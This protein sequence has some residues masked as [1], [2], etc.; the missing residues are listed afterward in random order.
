[1]A[2]G[3]IPIHDITPKLDSSLSDLIKVFLVV[4]EHGEREMRVDFQVGARSL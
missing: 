4:Q 3:D 1:M 2:E